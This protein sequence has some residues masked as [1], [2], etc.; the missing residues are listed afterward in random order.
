M[1]EAECEGLV[2]IVQLSHTVQ[3]LFSHSDQ[4][5]LEPLDAENQSYAKTMR[6]RRCRG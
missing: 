5:L 2:V 4:R 1:M 3:Y 6:L